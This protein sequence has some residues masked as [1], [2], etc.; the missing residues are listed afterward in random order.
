M[1]QEGDL[2]EIVYNPHFKLKGYFISAQPSFSN[3]FLVKYYDFISGEQKSA[4]VSTNTVIRNKKRIKNYI[5]CITCTVTNK[6]YIGR[7]SGTIEER[8]KQHFHES[9]QPYSQTPLHVDMRKYGK[10]YFCIE[11]VCEYYADRQKDAN[12]VEQEFIRMYNTQ[13]PYGYNKSVY[14]KGI[15]DG[16]KTN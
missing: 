12:K 1:I 13:V 2:I 10:K 8:F 14:K 9:K 7:T 4:V 15:Y 6:K 5:Y 16:K 3:S 11:K